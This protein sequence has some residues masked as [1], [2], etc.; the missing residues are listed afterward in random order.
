MA[1]IWALIVGPSRGF[2]TTWLSGDGANAAAEPES[3]TTIVLL[4]ELGCDKA[5]G[6]LP[7]VC[8]FEPGGIGALE[9][10]YSWAVTSTLKSVFTKD[11]SSGSK[12]DDE[13]RRVMA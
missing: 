10:A 11:A 12:A 4:A 3:S 8:W 2:M 7:N 1:S 5:L 13:F 9:S 6:E